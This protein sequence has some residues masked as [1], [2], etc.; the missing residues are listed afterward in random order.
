MRARSLTGSRPPSGSATTPRPCWRASRR[1]APAW[2][3]R[4]WPTTPM[5]RAFSQSW[6]ARFRPTPWCWP[7][8]ASPATGWPAT[9]G[10]H[11]RARWRIRW[12]GGRWDSPSRRRW[13]PRSPTPV[14]WCACAAMEASSSRAANWPQSLRPRCRSRWSSSTTAA[15]GC[16]AST[17]SW[18]AMS[19]SASISS[20]RTSPRWHAR[21]GIGAS[22][23]E[24]FGAE[25]EATL[26]HSVTTP[27]PSLIVVRAR[28]RPPPTTSPRWY[29]RPAAG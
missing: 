23:V 20:G 5:R 18:P 16:C 1:S 25:F 11:G 26:R 21:S 28:L 17:R 14:R 13:A 6:T 3:P 12:G 10:S 24:G 7:T 2:P 9:D 27:A 19:R 29:R 4:C 22:T 8:C 15:T